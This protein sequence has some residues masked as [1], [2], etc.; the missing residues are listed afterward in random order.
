MKVVN[1]EKV[2]E[3]YSS[4]ISSIFISTSETTSGGLS[5]ESG[6]FG[7]SISSLFESSKSISKDSPISLSSDS[8]DSFLH[9]RFFFGVSDDLTSVCLVKRDYDWNSKKKRKTNSNTRYDVIVY[10][11]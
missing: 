8:K 3:N 10:D 6:R 5:S 9:F 11:S 4:P 2:S 1:S 7:F